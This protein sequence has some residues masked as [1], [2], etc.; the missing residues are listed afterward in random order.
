MVGALVDELPL[1]DDRRELKRGSKAWRKREWD[2]YFEALWR[3]EG[4]MPVWMAV[5]QLGV[6]RQRVHQMMETG[7]L[8]RLEFFGKPFVRGD[9]VEA[10]QAMEKER[11][12]PAFRWSTQNS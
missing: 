12:S 5:M 10:L 3:C 8:E 11:H 2:R 1:N 9:E 4:L 6:S 7:V